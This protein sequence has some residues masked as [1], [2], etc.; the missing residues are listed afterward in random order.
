MTE[1]RGL[2]V[3]FTDGSKLKLDYPKQTQSEAATFVKLKE[4]LASRL[5]IAE[6]DGVALMI[7]F[8]NIRYL[9]AHPA[10]KGMPE[11]ALK[12]ATIAGG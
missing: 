10:P 7:P 1:R 9:E 5:I 11:Y 3:Y 4:I 2:T 12:G 8:D 6:V